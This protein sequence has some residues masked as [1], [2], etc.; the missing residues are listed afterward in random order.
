MPLTQLVSQTTIVKWS[1]VLPLLS[2]STLLL[3]FAQVAFR[4]VYGPL[5]YLLHI[6]FRFLAEREPRPTPRP[7]KKGR[8]G[9]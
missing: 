4:R 1:L 5:F 6:F 2:A 8:L 3:S 9:I 7:L